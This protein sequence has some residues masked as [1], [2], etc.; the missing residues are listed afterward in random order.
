MDAFTIEAFAL[1]G[2]G[3]AV[4]GLRSILEAEH[5]ISK[6]MTTLCFWLRMGLS[7][8]SHTQVY[9][10]YINIRSYLQ[11]RHTWHTLWGSSGT[12]L[13]TTAATDGTAPARSFQRRVQIT[14]AGW[15]TYTFLLWVLKAAMCTF[16][17]RL[18]PLEKNW[19]IY[20]RPR[21]HVPLPEAT[22]WTS[23]LTRMRD[24]CQPAISKVDIFVTVVL[25]VGD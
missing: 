17:V 8:L 22:S 18:T 5:R 11:L 19:Q 10:N 13:P 25:N 16:Y 1:L 2:I 9:A 12:A 4:I 7:R 14:I 21:Q 3:L 6:P 15:S 23:R 20:P 24:F